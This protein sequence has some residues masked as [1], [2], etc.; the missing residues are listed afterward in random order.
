[1][2]AARSARAA[3]N[4]QRPGL[5]RKERKALT[6]AALLEAATRSICRD[7]YAGASVERI[8]RAAGFTK[9]AFYASFRSKEE[10]FLTILD[11]K[12]ARELARLEETLQGGGDPVA[13]VKAAIEGFLEQ[14]DSEPT[15][16]R[17][18]Q[19]FAL[20]AARNGRFRAQL[21]SR[22][23]R[24]R[25]R[26]AEIFLRWARTIGVEPPLPPEEIATLNYVMADGF[27]LN[28]ILDPTLDNRYYIEM[29]ET[30]L[31]GLLARVEGAQL[32]SEPLLTRKGGWS[33]QADDRE[34]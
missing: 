4:G 22:Q 9:G 20:Y 15:W 3:K 19:E 12:F 25:K 2:P 8:A 18:Y 33:D 14:V 6:R 24:L 7:G 34:V 11:E 10:L 27:L 32:G 26:M 31:L 1:V 29:V 23:R 30:F 5:S 16:P 21:V 28:R 17:L 13:E